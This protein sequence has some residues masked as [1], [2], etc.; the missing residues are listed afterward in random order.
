M[1]EEGYQGDLYVVTSNVD[2][3]CIAKLNA[4]GG[5][6]WNKTNRSGIVQDMA[7]INGEVFVVSNG[8]NEKYDTPTASWLQ[9]TK[10]AVRCRLPK[11]R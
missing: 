4:M 10:P 1:V 3:R 9:K 5:I 7:L 8:R 11:V 2:G 6:Y